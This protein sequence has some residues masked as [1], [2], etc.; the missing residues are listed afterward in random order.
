ARD[1]H[2]AHRS[3]FVQ[4]RAGVADRGRESAAEAAVVDLMIALAQ[5][6]RGDARLQMRLAA[7]RLGRR[8]P[9]EIEP[10]PGLELVGMTELLGIVAVEGE[11]ERA[12]VA[13]F[14]RNAGCGFELAREIGPSTLAF[15]RER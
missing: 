9:F 5:D 6:G 3:V 11:D 12:L 2:L 13:V 1:D 10:E 4:R 7:A 14:D 8:Q 15:E